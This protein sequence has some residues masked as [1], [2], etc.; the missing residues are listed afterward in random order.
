M[1]KNF[2]TIDRNLSL[3]LFTPNIPISEIREINIGKYRIFRDGVSGI[4][5]GENSALNHQG[6]WITIKD[7]PEYFIETK[8]QEK[9]E[10]VISGQKD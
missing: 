9:L 5:T 1:K 7:G 10:N 4:F 8:N 3:G 6:V 2:V